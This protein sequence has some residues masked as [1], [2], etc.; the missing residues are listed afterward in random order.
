VKK[1]RLYSFFLLLFLW[2]A[3][4][5]SSASPKGI[6]DSFSILQKTNCVTALA[7]SLPTEPGLESTNANFLV[8]NC[9]VHSSCG[10]LWNATTTITDTKFF[11]SSKKLSNIAVSSKKYLV[12]IHPSHNF[13]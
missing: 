9:R 3:T 8:N 7:D 4:L 5:A 6:D 2:V 1:Y 12:H 13:W 10:H 11:T